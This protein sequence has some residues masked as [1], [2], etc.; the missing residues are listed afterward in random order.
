MAKLPRAILNPYVSVYLKDFL[1]SVFPWISIRMS[2][3]K[4]MLGLNARKFFSLTALSLWNA[5]KVPFNYQLRNSQIFKKRFS[6]MPRWFIDTKNRKIKKRQ[7]VQFENNAK[8]IARHTKGE[9]LSN[10]PS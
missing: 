6:V 3:S 8:S 10:Q 4:L 5:I 2:I 1:S 7:A 9:K